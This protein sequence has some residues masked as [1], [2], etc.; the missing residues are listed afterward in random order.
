LGLAGP[1]RFS[2]HAAQTSHV[3]FY[4]FWPCIGHPFT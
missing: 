2:K 4:L 1:I 3:F